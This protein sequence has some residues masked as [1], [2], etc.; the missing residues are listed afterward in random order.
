MNLLRELLENLRQF[1]ATIGATTLFL[2]RVLGQVPRALLRPGL[3]V[4]QVH[5]AGALSLVII[6]TCGLFVGAVLG[7]QGYDLLQR[8]GSEDALGTA[9]A[10]ALIK[11]LGP[12]VTALLFAGR[13]GTALASEIGL[14]RATDQLTAMEM[15]AVDPIRRV[16]AP[17]FLGGVI[18]MPLLTIIFIAIGIFG[19]QVVGVQMFGVDSA[20]FWSQM[21]ASVG[22]DDIHEGIIKG[23]V[24]GLACSLV[25]VYEGFTAVPTAEGVG[26]ATTRTVVTSAVLTLILDYMLTALML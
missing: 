20:S 26:R 3:I 11:E 22:M 2:G 5:N 25:A 6:M 16:V 18:A 23:C 19:V 17:R 12:V 9:A 14:M 8:F 24:F 21:R 7:L 4:E 1:V 10:L 15:M 13:A